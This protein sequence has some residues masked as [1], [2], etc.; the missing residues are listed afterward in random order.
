MK[1]N[2]LV[3]PSSFFPFK[4]DKFDLH[5]NCKGRIIKISSSFITVD[6][7]YNDPKYPQKKSYSPDMLRV[8]DTLDV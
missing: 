3:M 7:N 4:D 8:C 5:R 2:D 6:W 1:I